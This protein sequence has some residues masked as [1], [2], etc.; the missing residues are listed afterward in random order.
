MQLKRSM[1]LIMPALLVALS[2]HVF[3]RGS[4]EGTGA[5]AEGP[6]KLSVMMREH[7]N[8]KLTNDWPFWD[9]TEDATDVRVDVIPVPVTDWETKFHVTLASDDLPDLISSS[10]SDAKYYGI[11]GAF[12]ALKDLIEDNAPW[13]SKYLDEY[14]SYHLLNQNENLYWFPSWVGPN[15]GG[16]KIPVFLTMYRE[17]W[18]ADL[19]ISE[20]KTMDEW[21]AAWRKVKA[22]KPE[23]VG[24]MAYGGVG[25]VFWQYFTGA[26]GFNTHIDSLGWYWRVENN[27]LVSGRTHDYYRELIEFFHTLYEEEILDKEY[28]TRTKNSWAEVVTAGN[29]FSTVY[30]GNRAL[31]FT[32][33]GR[34]A[35]I[36]DYSMI[37]A[38][39]P[40]G[41]YGQAGFWAGPYAENDGMAITKDNKHPVESIK[42][43]DYFISPEGV[44]LHYWGRKGVTY[45]LKDGEP[46]WKPGGD[47]DRN[48][49][50]YPEHVG[51][52]W[53]PFGPKRELPLPEKHIDP[54]IYQYGDKPMRRNMKDCELQ[55]PMIKLTDAEVE[56][57]QKIE[58]N[59]KPFFDEWT[60]DFI[61][62][63]KELNDAS[64]NEFV[65][66]LD[67]LGESRL[68]EIYT[69]AYQRYLEWKAQN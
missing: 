24:L 67:K 29:V 20:P 33:Q 8:S 45:E 26:Y 48:A 5:E 65:T 68:E 27:K 15:L 18:A 36:E 44:D 25:E 14:G 63:K 7:T 66:G 53:W 64:W 40:E 69:D 39:D 31:W 56:E 17:D 32:N 16:P 57:K 52:A 35:G 59:V 13:T 12:V 9:Y 4:Q 37:I 43:L 21:L 38:R 46:V 61:M 62:G 22:D 11:Q 2:V 49:N 60:N 1:L 6:T 42:F 41:P 55:I 51:P 28:L 58:S 54:M 47:P 34:Q 19:G 10:L 30:T 3:A 50:P 23:A